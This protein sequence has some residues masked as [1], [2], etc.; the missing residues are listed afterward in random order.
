MPGGYTAAMIRAASLP[1]LL[2]WGALAAAPAAAADTGD[3][4]GEG[5]AGWGEIAPS[6]PPP[7]YLGQSFDLRVGGGSSSAC[8]DVDTCVWWMDEFN[9][10]GAIAPDKGSPVAYTA[11]DAL[12]DCIPVSFQVFAS[13]ADGETQDSVQITVQ[14]TAEEK[15]SLLGRAG[16]TVGG[17]GC[18]TSGA[19]T[20]LAWPR[21]RR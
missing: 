21:R 2:L 4:P 12:D 8:G 10:V 14:C 9:G 17:G 1:P 7:L 11:P 20:V 13:C 19:A 5:C 6:E 3:V 18:G 15:A 16:S